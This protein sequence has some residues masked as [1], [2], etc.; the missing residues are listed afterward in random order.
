[1]ALG[2]QPGSV[3]RVFIVNGLT[4]AIAGIA[5]GLAGSAALTRVLASSLFGV[6]P[7]D[8]LTFAAVSFGLAV[9]A[10]I[11]SYVPALRAMKVDSLETLR[12]E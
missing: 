11:A 3:A 12:V 9:T 8:P 2:A 7:L 6:T 1:M 5:C 10:L 4:L